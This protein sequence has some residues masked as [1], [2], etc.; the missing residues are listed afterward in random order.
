S[1]DNVRLK[2]IV[3]VRFEVRKGHCG[4]PATGQPTK[5]DRINV[6]FGSKADIH[7]PSAD[8]CF[9]SESG[10]R[11][12]RIFFDVVAP[13]ASRYSPQST[14]PHRAHKQLR[15]RSPAINH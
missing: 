1:D 15:G 12:W 7:P 13:A 4:A 5:P 6:R 3:D 2:G 8:V 9:T 14:P 10:H 11:N